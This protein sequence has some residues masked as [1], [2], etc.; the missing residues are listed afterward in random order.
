M[1]AVEFVNKPSQIGKVKASGNFR[2]NSMNELL[3]LS[4]S[5]CCC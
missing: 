2:M 1:Y 3:H 5:H 4:K